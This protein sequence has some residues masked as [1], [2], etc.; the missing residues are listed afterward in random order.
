MCVDFCS[1]ET[2]AYSTK[3][4]FCHNTDL[5]LLIEMVFRIALEGYV[6]LIKMKF[7][8]FVSCC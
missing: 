6:L 8:T 7:Q 1:D 2:I 3:N 5:V 4:I